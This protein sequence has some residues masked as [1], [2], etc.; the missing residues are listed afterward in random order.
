MADV[1]KYALVTG[2]SSGIGRNISEELAKRGYNIVAVSNQP[3][4]LDDLKK[5]IELSFAVRVIPLNIDLAVENSAS[6]VFDSCKNLNIFVEVLVNNAGIFIFGEAARTDHRAM[7]SILVLHMVTPVLLSRLF[8]ESMVSHGNGYI[9]NVSSITSVMPYPGISLYGPT[10]A[11]LRHFTRAIR[12]EMKLYGVKVTCLIPGAVATPLY[13]TDKYNT[14]LLRTLGLMKKP[15]SVAKAGVSA[16]F[17]NRPECI[18][19]LLNKIIV[20]LVPLV[21]HSIICLINRRINL[22][23]K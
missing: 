6:E 12:T 5:N 13:G 2:A 18:P 3:V 20:F 1:L 10:K 17:R 22:V 19:G 16:L 8:G 21:P 11:F 7:R 9:L 23:R 15:D 14:P 4:Q